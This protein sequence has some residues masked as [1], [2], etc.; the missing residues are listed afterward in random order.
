MEAELRRWPVRRSLSPA[1]FVA[2]LVLVPAVPAAAG[3]N[4]LGFKED[5]RVD[6]S[7]P[8][9]GGD[10]RNLG[11]WAVLHVGQHVVAATGIYAPGPRHR[12]LEN[13]GPFYAWLVSEGTYRGGTRLPDAA[14]R[15][16]PFEIRWFSNRSSTVRARFT[17]P[18]VPSGAYEVLVCD[19]PCTYPGFGEFVEGWVTVMQTPDEARLLAVARERKWKGRALAH[20]VKHLQSEVAALDAEVAAAGTELRERTLQARAAASRNAALEAARTTAESRPVIP[21]WAVGMLAA[22]IVGVAVILRRRR[23]RVFVVPDTVPDDLLQGDRVGSIQPEA[24]LLDE[25]AHRV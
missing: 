2:L 4:W 1:L 14:I 20:K 19:D 13:D 24:L 5:P 8:G 11:T 17:V 7:Q 12:H 22:S 18:A 25:Q 6:A 21:G 9:P 15:L 10:D 16:A 3:G 23:S